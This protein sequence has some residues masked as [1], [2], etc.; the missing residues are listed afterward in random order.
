MTT[1]RILIGSRS[2]G[3][4]FPEH[5]R[6]LEEAGFEV[7][8]NTV[9]RALRAEE[10]ESALRDIDAIV[11]GTDELTRDVIFGA[12][13]LRLIAKHGVGLENVDLEAAELRGIRVVSTPGA[14]TEA[15]AELTFALLL[16]LLRGIVSAHNETTAGGWPRMVGRELCGKTI[17]LVGYG[18]IA[19]EV[20]TRA[21]AFGM[22]VVASDPFLAD[23]ELELLDLNALLS[24]A[25]VVS[26]HA[27]VTSTRPLIGAVELGRMKPDAVLVNTSRGALIDE[28]ALAVALRAGGIAGAALD[29]FAEEPPV[30]SALLG[31]PNLVLTPHLGGQTSEALRRMGEL[32]VHACLETFA[33][34]DGVTVG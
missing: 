7:I 28:D 33:T 24:I 12:D 27:A 1:A 15:V 20:E 2:F 31:A 8:P 25:D 4:T 30:G 6:A 23:A 26:L 14:M 21:R 10:L 3:Q 19:R 9:G 32:T 34:A 18:R 29:V 16:A 5:V 13:R 11:T 22:K 17:G